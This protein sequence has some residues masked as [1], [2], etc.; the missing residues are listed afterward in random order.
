MLWPLPGFV[1]V[2]MMM[3][4]SIKYSSAFG[5]AVVYLSIHIYFYLG[6]PIRWVDSSTPYVYVVPALRPHLPHLNAIIAR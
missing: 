4:I 3:M 2:I 5:L 1:E 6:L